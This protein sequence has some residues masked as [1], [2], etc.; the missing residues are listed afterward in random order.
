MLEHVH[1]HSFT[2]T[3]TTHIPL[4][5]LTIIITRI[6]HRIECY[7][8]FSSCFR[9]H[10]K[11]CPDHLKLLSYNKPAFVNITFQRDISKSN[12]NNKII[13]AT[14]SLIVTWIIQAARSKQLSW[15]TCEPPKSIAHDSC[16]WEVQDQEPSPVSG[17]CS[18]ESRGTF[19]MQSSYDGRSHQPVLIFFSKDTASIKNLPS[20]LLLWRLN[21]NIWLYESHSYDIEVIFKIKVSFFF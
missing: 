1:R 15:V 5:S 7:Q 3:S 11:V 18:P 14:G 21:C 16:N 4:H 8:S 9:K 12:S 6:S 10:I 13:S 17:E 20:I 2:A 19:C